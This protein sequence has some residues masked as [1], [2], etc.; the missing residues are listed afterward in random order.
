MTQLPTTYRPRFLTGMVISESHGDLV[1]RR[2]LLSHLRKEGQTGPY[3]TAMEHSMFWADIAE[4]IVDTLWDADESVSN[5]VSEIYGAAHTLGS[6]IATHPGF[7]AST[8]YV[9]LLS[10]AD[11]ANVVAVMKTLTADE[12]E[13]IYAGDEWGPA[14]SGYLKLM[15][16]LSESITIDV[17]HESLEATLIQGGALNMPETPLVYS[18]EIGQFV[19]TRNTLNGFKLRIPRHPA[20]ADSNTPVLSIQY[21]KPAE[22]TSIVVTSST[23]NVPDPDTPGSEKSEQHTVSL[24]KGDNVMALTLTEHDMKYHEWVFTVG[25]V[26]E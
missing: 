24:Q 21:P 25:K 14:S 10:K 4:A 9:Y 16:A 18:K 17:L 8:E 7:A 13:N 1:A 19:V 15:A 5:N 26:A 22:S 2:A 12:I 23:D 3:V 6:S 11:A 20:F